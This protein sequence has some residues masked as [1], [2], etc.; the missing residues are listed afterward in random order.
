[1]PDCNGFS[2]LCITGLKHIL[3]PKVSA[4]RNHDL[5]QQSHIKPSKITENCLRNLPANELEPGF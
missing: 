2:P 1:M 3:E 4:A 5:M